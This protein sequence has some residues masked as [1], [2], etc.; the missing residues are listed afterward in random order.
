VEQA[1]LNRGPLDYD[2]LLGVEQVDTCGEQCLEAGWDLEL[3]I[4]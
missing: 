4:R 1:P 2:A 3:T